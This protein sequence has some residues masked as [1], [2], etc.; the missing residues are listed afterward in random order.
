M[1]INIDNY[2][3]YL[4]DYQEGNLNSDETQQLRQFIAAQGLDWDE[5]TEELP[6]LQ[7]S[8]D[9]YPDKENLKKRAVTIPLFVKIATLAAA[10]ALLFIVFWKHDETL[11]KQEMIAELK[12]IAA[13]VLE[14]ETRSF[15]APKKRSYQ[16]KNQI[17]NPKK[18][19]TKTERIEMPILAELPPLPAPEL[20]LGAH[21]Y[22]EIQPNV[23]LPLYFLNEYYAFEDPHENEEDDD[24]EHRPSLIDKGIIWLSDGR[25]DSFGNLINSALHQ[26][27]KEVVKTTTKVAM[28]AY[29]KADYEIEEA[30]ER[31]Q[32]KWDQKEG[33]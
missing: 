22:K 26:A 20:E 5:L 4:L 31:W 29:Y 33:E 7:A 2:E 3:A 30:K 19:E 18:A 27:K 16:V 8:F 12:P 24:Y 9:T 32:E 28:T 13:S 25:Y 11:P 23:P 15:V 6:H 10:V 14:A 1:N 17:V 21:A